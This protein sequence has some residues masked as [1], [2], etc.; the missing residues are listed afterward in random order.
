[1]FSDDD[2]SGTTHLCDRSAGSRLL[3]DAWA[4]KFDA[5][6]VY[7]ADRLGRSALVNETLAL[8][9]HGKLGIAIIGVSDSIDLTSPI[10]AAML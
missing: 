1:M 2:V 5:V 7:K 4:G 8:E 3:S 9:L 6:V 10:G